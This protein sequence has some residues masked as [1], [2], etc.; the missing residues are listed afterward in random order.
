MKTS[1]FSSS[2]RISCILLL[3]HT[4]VLRSFG[5]A[6]DV[7]LSFDPGSGVDGQISAIIVQPD[8]KILIAGSFSTVKGLLRTN[9][10][11]L[12]G[13]GSGDPTFDAGPTRNGITA[14][15]LQP[16]GRL[17]V[18][19]PVL[20]T[21]CD[22]SGCHTDYYGAVVRLNADGSQ[23]NTFA[24]AFAEYSSVTREF[25]S[26][27][28]LPDGKILVGGEFVS[29]NG[30]NRNGLARLNADGTLDTNFNASGLNG[31]VRQVIA[32][33]DGKV[34]IAGNLHW[35]DGTNHFG[36]VRL[37]ANGSFDPTFNAGFVSV[38][39][40]DCGALFS[41][42][43]S[44]DITAM[45]LQPNG[46]LLVGIWKRL[47]QTPL[48]G[49]EDLITDHYSVQRLN[50]NGSN[51][52]S[53]VF[54]N[55]AQLGIVQGIIA[56]PDGR[57]LVRS[58][59]FNTSQMARLDADGSWDQSF[60]PENVS[61]TANAAGLQAD[62]KILL[63]GA[64]ILS[65]ETSVQRMVRLN[66]D[67]S[68]DT[69][70]DSGKG[71]ENVVSQIALQPDGKVLLGGP[72]VIGD[73]YFGPASDVL[74]FINGTNR[75]GRARLNFDGSLDGAFIP[76]PFHPPLEARYHTENCPGDPRYGCL[77]AFVS[78]AFLVQTDGKVLLGGSFITTIYGED[79]LYQVYNSFLGRLTANGGLEEEF[80][81]P[82]VAVSSLAQ[83][84]DGKIVMGG[85]LVLNG[86]NS[87]VARLNYDGTVDGS[88]QLGSGPPAVVALALQTDGK[89]VVAG[90]NK[91]IRLNSNGT[92]DSGFG[93]ASLSNGVAYALALQSG[94]KVLVAGSFKSVNGITRNRIAR[95]SANG[96]LDLEFN[97]GLGADGP[98]RSMALQTDGKV[99]IS[100]EF[101]TVAG[102]LRPFVARLHG[103]DVPPALSIATSNALVT[104]SWPLST[105]FVLEQSLTTT[106]VWS[107]VLSPYTT[108]GNV[109]SVSAPVGSGNKFYRLHKL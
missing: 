99:V 43:E 32:Q 85:S 73:P 106:G 62:G 53:F 97:P 36:V 8:G 50:A 25:R 109:L 29:V 96:S 78:T 81:L 72:L 42:W 31:A 93:P 28:S 87:T 44:T 14:M 18:A 58:G 38:R 24:P 40:P 27:V 7:D 89:I 98:I 76:T 2:I 39:Y 75:H 48:D 70:F 26:L 9:L 103:A 95:L 94:G 15:T 5:A 17:L 100:G 91:V 23:D 105:G 11:R 59:G 47:L 57:L 90:A 68:L 41:C 88:F 30:T 102:V 84:P 22:E 49:S 67:G 108:N 10:A 66:A 60:H 45:T 74:P 104:I 65:P 33:P 20:Q 79:L 6:G 1:C 46:K 63:G 80:N 77:Q 56:Q 19:G 52:G 54:T 37:N 71:L 34:L 82:G 69:T 61:G 107:Q 51:D 55:S 16:D 35:I 83:Q 4:I 3:V 92:L 101:K 64:P 86:T 21:F 12:N 13:D